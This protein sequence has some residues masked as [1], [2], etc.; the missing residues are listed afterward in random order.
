MHAHTHTPTHPRTHAATRPHAHTT[1]TTQPHTRPPTQACIEDVDD[2]IVKCRSI[3]YPCMLKASA[4]GGG[5][6]IR[7]V[8]FV[9]CQLLLLLL[10]GC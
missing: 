4:G 7:K 1:I 9:E 5:K 2:A 8:S 6:G 10:L 3:G